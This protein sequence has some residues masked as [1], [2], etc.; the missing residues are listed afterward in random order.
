MDNGY[1]L[2]LPQAF[3]QE[4]T[5]TRRKTENL[6][7]TVVELYAAM[8][9]A[10]VGYAYQMMGSSGDAEDLVQIAFLKLFDQLQKSV[11]IENVRSWLYRVIH[12]EAIDQMRHHGKQE[13]AMGMWMTERIRNEAVE[14]TELDFIQ[15]QRIAQSLEGL[16]PRERNCLVLRAEGLSYREISAVLAISEKAVSVYLARGL[17]KLEG[18]HEASA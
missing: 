15:R 10:L 13:S 9:P 2:G 12:N 17:K 5:E 7:N 1:V 8:R 4:H 14:N 6:E 16:N 3:G 18:K 11:K